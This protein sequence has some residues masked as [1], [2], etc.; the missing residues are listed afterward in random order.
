MDSG[1]SVSMQ[2]WYEGR[3]AAAKIRGSNRWFL[4]RRS[5]GY[6]AFVHSSRVD[7]R[8]GV[9]WCGDLSRVKA[10][11]LALS[12][13]GKTN[14]QQTG[15]DGYFTASDWASGPYGEWS[16]DCGKFAWLAY[17]RAGN[18][19]TLDDAW[20]MFSNYYSAGYSERG[21]NELPPYGALVG[22][23]SDPGH[24]AV[25][26]G[27][28]NVATTQGWNGDGMWIARRSLADSTSFGGPNY[29]GWVVPRD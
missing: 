26:V 10:G 17:E 6:E 4:V 22:W 11:L 3:S 27:G 16:G 21:R 19:L 29:Y 25:A 15:D 9:G 8:T 20:P 5:D 13:L 7:A 12:R 28:P 18:H 23:Q 24:I 14:A 2:C 1:T